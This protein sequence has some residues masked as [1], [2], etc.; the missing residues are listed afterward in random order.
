MRHSGEVV[1]AA[2][3]PDGISI[4]SGGTDGTVRLWDAKS[5]R[6]V[7][8]LHGHT[9]VVK[10][11][12]F[13]ADGRRLV[14]ASL[15]EPDTSYPGDGTV[16]QWEVGPQGGATVLRGHTSY[17]YPVA[18]SPDGQWIASGSW[19]KTIRLWDAETGENSQSCPIIRFC[20]HWRLAPTVHGLLPVEG[21]RATG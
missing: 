8:V 5:Q 14:S 11:L 10:E 13:L 12:A 4:A 20:V 16:R 15:N 2:Y 9:G 3:S 17:V 21:P 19:D 1:T 18:F 6:D 7:A